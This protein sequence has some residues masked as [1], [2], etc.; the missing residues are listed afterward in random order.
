MGLDPITVGIRG[1]WSSTAILSY[2]SGTLLVSVSRR[3]TVSDLDD[4]LERLSQ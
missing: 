4:A 1:R 2:L 3:L